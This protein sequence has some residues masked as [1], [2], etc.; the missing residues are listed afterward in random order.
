MALPVLLSPWARCFPAALWFSLCTGGRWEV[1]RRTRWELG[2]GEGE[3]AV[4]WTLQE[5]RGWNLGQ[6][7]EKI[8]GV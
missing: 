7:L 6:G 3:S 2:A 5:G 4:G 1:S 8:H